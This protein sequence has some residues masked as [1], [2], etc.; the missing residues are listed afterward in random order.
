VF[1][2]QVYGM[3]YFE[4]TQWRKTSDKKEYGN[5]VGIE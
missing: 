3:L 1:G 2:G 4:S 5:L